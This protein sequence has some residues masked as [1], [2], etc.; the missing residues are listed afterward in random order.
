MNIYKKLINKFPDKLELEDSGM[1]GSSRLFKLTSQYRYYSHM[2]LIT[3]PVGFITDG[4]SFPR[5]MW[6]IFY[7]FDNSFGAAVIHDYLYS[8]NNNKFTRREADTIF[9]VG[10]SAFG[11]S[12]LKRWIVYY[13]LRIFGCFHYN[14]YEN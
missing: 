10:M 12:W 7:P 11:V 8:K 5:I 2:G 9:R 3:V 4:S 6:S 1:R 14:G 13:T